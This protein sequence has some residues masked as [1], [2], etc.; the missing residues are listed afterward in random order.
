MM[1]QLNNF[2][3]FPEVISCLLD[4][5]NTICQSLGILHNTELENLGLFFVQYNIAGTCYPP[6]LVGLKER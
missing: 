4:L 2:E 5:S 3:R 1:V 6:C